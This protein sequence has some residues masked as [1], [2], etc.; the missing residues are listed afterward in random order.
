MD[1]PAR[2]PGSLAQIASQFDLPPRRLA[3]VFKRVLRVSLREYAEAGRRARFRELVRAGQPVTHALY[4]AGFGS[5]SRLYENAAKH[6]GMTPATYRRGG[7]GELVRYATTRCALGFILVAATDRGVCHVRIGD[8]RR[9]LEA[10]L[11]HEFPQSRLLKDARRLAS[12]VRTILAQLDGAP[13]ASSVPLDVRSTAFQWRVWKELMT[14]PVGSTLSYSEV[15]RR[16]GRPSAVRAVARACATNPVAIVVP[17]HR[18]VRSD[19]TLGG[20]RWGLKRKEKILAIERQ[21]ALAA[22]ASA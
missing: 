15:A 21:V 7:V 18:V 9:E 12:W 16:V 19:G 3:R 13:S 8:S 2:E 1:D 11:R 4:A 14:I 10:G 6:L 5:S 20:Y 17:C 22:R